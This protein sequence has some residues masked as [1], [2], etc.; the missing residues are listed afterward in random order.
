MKVVEV[1]NT[2]KRELSQCT[3]WD[4]VTRALGSAISELESMDIVSEALRAKIREW[5][6]EK[7]HDLTDDQ[8]EQ[9]LAGVSYWFSETVNDSI[10][11]A[12][13]IVQSSNI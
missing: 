12:Y 1:I 8:V 5:A 4:E 9:M 3:C 7:S 2:M 13:D 10:S 6:E 11:T